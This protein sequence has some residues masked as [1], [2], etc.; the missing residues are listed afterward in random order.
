MNSNVI[1]KLADNFVKF[2]VN[3]RIKKSD[4]ILEIAK[5]Q[6]SDIDNEYDKIKFINK[7]LEGNNIAYEYHLNEECT[8]REECSENMAREAINYFLT[9]ELKRLGVK[10]GDDAF[11]KDE[12]Q[13]ADEKLNKILEQFESMPT[14]NPPGGTAGNVAVGDAA[15]F[16][17]VSRHASKESRTCGQTDRRCRPSA[18]RHRRLS[19]YPIATSQPA[20]A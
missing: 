3:G 17:G 9:Q 10:M 1:N 6:V 13:V 20:P 16:F 4:E 2:N 15:C 7:I 11:T 18:A 5:K 19:A 14:K 8:N 12:K